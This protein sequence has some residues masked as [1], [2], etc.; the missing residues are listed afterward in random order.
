MEWLCVYCLI[1]ILIRVCVEILIDEN[2]KSRFRNGDSNFEVD[3]REDDSIDRRKEIWNRIIQGLK[4][5]RSISNHSLMIFFV[6]KIK[7]WIL[8]K[9]ISHS[10]FSIWENYI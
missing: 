3:W 2:V 4:E 1:F 9:I 8:I 10:I 5:Q 7:K 6:I